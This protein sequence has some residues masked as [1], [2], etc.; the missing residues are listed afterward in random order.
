[1][2]YTGIVTLPNQISKSKN[3]RRIGRIEW[4][5]VVILSVF[6]HFDFLFLIF[7]HAASGLFSLITAMSF[8]IFLTVF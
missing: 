3:Q 7:S 2:L 6:L 5:L 8:P 1:M 4:L